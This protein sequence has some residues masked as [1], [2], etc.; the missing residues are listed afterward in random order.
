[1]FYNNFKGTVPAV[2]HS[3]PVWLIAGCCTCHPYP[4]P[5]N[6]YRTLWM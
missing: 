3:R 2:S 1:M 5:L 4:S 6:K